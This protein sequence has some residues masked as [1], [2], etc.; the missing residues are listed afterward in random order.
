MEYVI[1]IAG[2]LLL[3]VVGIWYE[4]TRVRLVILFIRRMLGR[5]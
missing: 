5:R 3:V 1:P 2:I 4:V